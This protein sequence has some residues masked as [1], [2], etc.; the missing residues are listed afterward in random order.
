MM[1]LIPLLSVYSLP[2]KQ[3]IKPFGIQLRTTYTVFQP[4]S[5]FDN[6]NKAPDVIALDLLK[7]YGYVSNDLNMRVTSSYSSK[8]LGVSHIY[9]VQT[10]KGIDIINSVANINLD[11]DG[12]LLSFGHTFY[13]PNDPATFFSDDHSVFLKFST[14]INNHPYIPSMPKI[15]PLK[16]VSILFTYLGLNDYSFELSTVTKTEDLYII[17]HPL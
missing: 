11:R 10:Y 2:V 12:K 6:I 16:A 3:G 5:T 9:L 15:E 8:Q 7:S 13:K 1:L 14:L 17:T 4:G